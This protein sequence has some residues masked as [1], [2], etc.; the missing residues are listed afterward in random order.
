MSRSASVFSSIARA[1]RGLLGLS[2]A[3]ALVAAAPAPAAAIPTPTDEPLPSLLANEPVAEPVV[4]APAPHKSLMLAARLAVTARLNPRKSRSRAAS[5]RN[6]GRGRG[7]RPARAV[8]T[9]AKRATAG[10]VWLGAEY[11]KRTQTP[12]ANVVQFKPKPK[13]ARSHSQRGASASPLR[14]AA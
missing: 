14:R 4:A 10:P 6:K 5:R 1:L 2:Q 12:S 8:A 11:R 7:N 3:Q 9:R 13:T